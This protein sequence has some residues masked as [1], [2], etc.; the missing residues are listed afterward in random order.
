M[1]RLAGFLG[2]AAVLA[3]LLPASPTLAQ[4]A[5]PPPPNPYN[6][7]LSVSAN[8]DQNHGMVNYQVND[9]ASSGHGG[10]TVA[11]RS[12]NCIGETA[13]QA[14]VSFGGLVRAQTATDTVVYPQPM[15]NGANLSLS[16][17][18]PSAVNANEYIVVCGGTPVG[19]GFWTPSPNSAPAPT[20]AQIRTI[21][22]SAAGQVPMP[23]VAIEANPPVGGGTVHVD[24]WFYATGYNGGPIRVTPPTPG[25]TI[26]IVATPTSYV[27]HFGDGS[28]PMSTTSLGVPWQA[29]YTP[30]TAHAD[31]T[32]D[33]TPTHIDATVPGA[34][35]HCWTAPSSGVTVS[36]T[37]NFAV[38]Y[39]VNGGA[40]IP[41]P[42]IQRSATLTYPVQVIDSL[43]TARG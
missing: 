15:Y 8:T 38:S 5:P 2:L 35:T 41:L 22:Q 21:A 7:H 24:T 43:V 23:N 40:Q 16:G 36:L 37:F 6:S 12:S 3:V 33:G 42:P 19:Y 17:T 10:S 11:H 13:Q 29:A 30:A 31:C 1:R 14:G 34:V 18:V 9:S 26:S 4:A 27:W 28:V 20:P 39:S 32:F 25:V